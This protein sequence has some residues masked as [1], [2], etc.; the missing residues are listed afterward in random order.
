MDPFGVTNRGLFGVVT[1][2]LLREKTWRPTHV[3]EQ[4]ALAQACAGRTYERP[5][6]RENETGV[7]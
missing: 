5:S 4:N 2:L 6:R 1:E 7:D 3:R